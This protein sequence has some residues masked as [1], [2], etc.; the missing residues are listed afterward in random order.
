METLSTVFY[1][2]CCWLVTNRSKN[3]RSPSNWKM[4]MF[5]PVISNTTKSFSRT[6]YILNVLILFI[7]VCNNFCE[8]LFSWIG[9]FFLNWRLIEV[10][11]FNFREIDWVHAKISAIKGKTWHIVSLILKSHLNLN[12]LHFIKFFQPYLNTF[13]QNHQN[14]TRPTP[15]VISTP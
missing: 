15:A 4:Q 2:I 1:R 6:F 5:I 9:S 14:T 10:L 8:Y 12:W 11:K 7:F 3:T 13:T